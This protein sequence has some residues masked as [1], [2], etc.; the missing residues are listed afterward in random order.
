MGS[1]PDGASPSGVLDLAGNVWEWVAD[2]YVAYDAAAVRD[3]PPARTDADLS[4]KRYGVRGGGWRDTDSSGV[5]SA[6]RNRVSAMFR[7]NDIG[8]RCARG[9]S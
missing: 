9:A 3:P 4:D 7:G 5:R 8:F 2:E 1:F 6:R